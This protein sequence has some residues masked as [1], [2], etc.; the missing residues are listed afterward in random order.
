MALGGLV[1][2]RFSIKLGVLGPRY[3]VGRKDHIKS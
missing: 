1:V 3:T 2:L